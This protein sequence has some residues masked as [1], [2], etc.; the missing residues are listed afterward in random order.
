MK[1]LLLIPI[2][3]LVLSGCRQDGTGSNTGFVKYEVEADGCIVKYVD[4][5]RG[6][7]FFI[8]KCPAES[9]TITNQ[10]PSGKSST[11]DVTVVTR[12]VEVLK[13]RLKLAQARESALGKL[14]AEERAALGVK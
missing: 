13:E 3:L 14:S 11:T 7:N 1:T 6:Y 8:A 2:A 10:R 9:Q 5:P 4:N 12:E